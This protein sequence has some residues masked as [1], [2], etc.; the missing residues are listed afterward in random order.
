M[1]L[2]PKNNNLNPEE[3]KETNI[4][5]FWINRVEFKK[6]IFKDNQAFGYL[7][8]R[9]KI[10]PEKYETFLKGQTSELEGKDVITFFDKKTAKFYHYFIVSR[11]FLTTNTWVIA[12]LQSIQES[13]NSINKLSLLGFNMTKNEY[14]TKNNLE[15]SFFI[16]YLKFEDKLKNVEIEKLEADLSQLNQEKEIIKDQLKLKSDNWTK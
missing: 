6:L 10:S 15:P 11:S 14:E 7:T 3:N 1:N 2:L 8:Y 12:S 16:N 13:Q 5:T 4:K 9:Q